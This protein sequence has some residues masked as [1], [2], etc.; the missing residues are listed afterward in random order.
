MSTKKLIIK[1]EQ[2]ILVI[3]ILF[4]LV[5]EIPF[6]SG[7]YSRV[8]SGKLTIS[9]EDVGFIA[10]KG[11]LD[12]FDQILNGDNYDVLLDAMNNGE[13]RG[14]TYIGNV[15][16][17]TGPDTEALKALFGENLTFG[18]KPIT[19]IIK[20]ED[21]DGDGSD[22]MT[23]YMTADEPGGSYRFGI[24]SNIV[25]LDVYAAVFECKLDAEGNTVWIQNG[26]TFA[27][28]AP[29]YPYDGNTWG[30]LEAI[31]CDSFRTDNWRSSQSYNGV[32]SPAVLSD[33]V[34]SYKQ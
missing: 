22:E 18:D 23:I 7:K 20:R 14:E 28:T 17:A 19:L 27:G 2:C 15:T 11:A 21:L 9:F 29:S 13:G 10:T 4:L 8:T 16:G 5:V 30:I 24:G 33:V 34:K 12:T 1:M 3:L 26:E 31:D 25:T 32:N 6:A